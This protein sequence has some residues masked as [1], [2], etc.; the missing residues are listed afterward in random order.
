MTSKHV[1][2]R[3]QCTFPDCT[4]TVEGRDANEEKAHE[5]AYDRLVK[6]K[7]R[8]NDHDYCKKCDLD[9]ECF[10]DFVSHKAKSSDKIHISCQWC[11]Q[12]FGSH[13]GR[14]AHIAQVRNNVPIWSAHKS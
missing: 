6:H 14:N 13:S 12:D 4:Q 1:I 8:N 11:G 3:L 9:F 2:V 5:K 10:D 7:I